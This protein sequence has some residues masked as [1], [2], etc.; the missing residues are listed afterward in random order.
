[1]ILRFCSSGSLVLVPLVPADD[2]PVLF[3]RQSGTCSSCTCRWSSGSVPLAVWYLFLY[4]PVDDHPV[5]FLWQSGTCSY[6]TCTPHIWFSGSGLQW[7]SGNFLLVSVLLHGPWTPDIFRWHPL[8][9]TFLAVYVFPLR[10]LIFYLLVR[11]LSFA[12]SCL[13][14][15]LF[16]LGN[17]A[18]FLFFLWLFSSLICFSK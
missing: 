16:L 6:C 18:L 10:W 8:L 5:L 7:L 17:T 9:I 12:P 3:L 11:F 2:P 15:F 13:L 4:V 14:F 1:M